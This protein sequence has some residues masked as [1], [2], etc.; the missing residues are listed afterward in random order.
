VPALKILLDLHFWIPLAALAG[1]V[2]LLRWL[3]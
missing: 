1:G 2:A 3:S